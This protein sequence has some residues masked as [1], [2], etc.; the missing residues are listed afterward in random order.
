MGLRSEVLAFAFGALLLLVT[1]GDNH[2]GKIAGVTIGNLD[3]ILGYRLWP[4]LDIVYPLATIA[5]FLLYGAVKWG[6]LRFTPLTVFLFALF[7]LLLSL[8]NL[9][10]IE[11]GLNRLGLPLSYD[12]SQAY[13]VVISWAYPVYSAAAFFVF[14]RLH[15]SRRFPAKK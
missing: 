11:I 2:L 5:V 8:V 9:D 3:T 14:G 1:F 12:P 4:V 6:Q 13:W 7:L 15:E 10:D